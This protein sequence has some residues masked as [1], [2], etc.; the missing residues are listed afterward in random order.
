MQET[1]L[2]A[3]MLFSCHLAMMN[4]GLNFLSMTYGIRK[5][6]GTPLPIWTT[7]TTEDKV[8]KPRCEVDVLL[9]I[10][11]TH[12]TYYHS[13]YKKREKKSVRITG[14]FDERKRTRLFIHVEELNYNISEEI[15]YLNWMHKCAVF[16]VTAPYPGRWNSFD[17][18]VWNSSIQSR[19]L[20]DCI[21]KFKKLQHRGRGIYSDYCQNI[22]HKSAKLPILRMKGEGK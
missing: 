20:G 17:V 3:V 14:K 2:F 7:N 21:R 8:G 11:K 6:L 10:S 4:C 5:F 15:V 22:V 1:N 9:T 19:H 12:I 13:C 18:R 16:K